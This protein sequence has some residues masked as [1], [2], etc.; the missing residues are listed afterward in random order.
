VFHTH[1]QP[2]VTLYPDGRVEIAE[3]H[4]VDE[5]ARAFWEAVRSMVPQYFKDQG[6]T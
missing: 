6:S 5:A 4:D 3:G 1:G 2:V